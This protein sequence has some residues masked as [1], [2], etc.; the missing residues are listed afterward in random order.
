MTPMR[1]KLINNW[2]DVR[3]GM[4]RPVPNLLCL[5]QDEGGQVFFMFVPKKAGLSQP[6]AQVPRN[7]A[8]SPQPRNR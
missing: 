4:F 7:Q 1:M 5:R 3:P 2:L 8:W 6:G